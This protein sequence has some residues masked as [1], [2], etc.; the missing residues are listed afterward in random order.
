MH[1]TSHHYAQMTRTPE[2]N[3]TNS[4]PV[5][6]QS[7]PSCANPNPNPKSKQPTKSQGIQ[8]N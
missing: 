6:M 8:Q 3:A 5:Q 4:T 7:L 2:A 1:D